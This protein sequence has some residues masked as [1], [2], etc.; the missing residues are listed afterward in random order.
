[1]ADEMAS[2]WRCPKDG[3]P[4][5]SMG[6]RPGAWRCPE[7]RG[8]FL[9]VATWRGGR[10]RPPAWAPVLMSVVASVIA[11]VIVRR[12]RRPTAKQAA[13]RTAGGGA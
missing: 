11:T 12:L 6:R 7:C 4:M 1:M 8:L 13:D 9:D 3:T 10:G 2:T 5:E